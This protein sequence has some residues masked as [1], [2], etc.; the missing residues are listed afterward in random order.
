MNLF[1]SVKIP[2]YNMGLEYLNMVRNK[3][4]E[5]LFYGN[6][7][8]VPEEKRSE[9]LKFYEQS[10]K[11]G[12]IYVTEGV[13]SIVTSFRKEDFTKILKEN[14]LPI[15]GNKTDLVNRIIENVSIN[16]IK[17]IGEIS[18]FIKLT[19]LGKTKLNEYQTEFKKQYDQFKKE[20]KLMFDSNKIKKACIK[21]NKF[22]ESYPFDRDGFFHYYSYKELYDLCLKIKKSDIFNI[23]ALP[24]A[25][26][27]TLRTTLYMYYSFKDFNYEQKF[28]EIYN[29]F[30]QLLIKSD[31]VKNKDFPFMDFNDY[32]RGY[33][34]TTHLEREKEREKILQKY[35]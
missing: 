8:L 34:I 22:N 10:I 24:K 21:V 7:S 5:H 3:R 13:E 30:E 33:R 23:I 19:D 9:V 26:H 28:E 17:E 15:S 6:T 25:Y 27:D 20:I 29:G 11:D 12:L 35:Q 32:I 18:N 16:Q 1:V 2:K 4:E 14:N 31:I